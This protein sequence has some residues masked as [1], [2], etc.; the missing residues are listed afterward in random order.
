MSAMAI[1]QGGTLTIAMVIAEHSIVEI[2]IGSWNVPALKSR[3]VYLIMT[4]EIHWRIH[5]NG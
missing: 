3:T 1:Y 5:M 2:R 4:E